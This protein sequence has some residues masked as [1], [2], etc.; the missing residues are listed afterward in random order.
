MFT[1]LEYRMHNRNKRT[2]FYEV[3][4]FTYLMVSIGFS[5]YNK[6]VSKSNINVSLLLIDFRKDFEFKSSFNNKVKWWE[7]KQLRYGRNGGKFRIILNSISYEKQKWRLKK[8]WQKGSDIF[9]SKETK[10]L[11]VYLFYDSIETYFQN[12]VY[13]LEMCFSRT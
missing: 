9:I 13:I 3:R 11:F 12:E 5:I 2:G 7:T 8:K 10:C 6:I 4:P 1:L